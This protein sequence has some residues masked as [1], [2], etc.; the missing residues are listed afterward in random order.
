[1]KNKDFLSRWVGVF[2]KQAFYFRFNPELH[3]CLI[4][5]PCACLSPLIGNNFVFGGRSIIEI[6]TIHAHHRK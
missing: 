4:F 2:L 5:T 6:S 3:F 1:M